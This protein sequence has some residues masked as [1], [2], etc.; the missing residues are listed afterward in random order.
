VLRKRRGSI[1]PAV[2]FGLL[3]IALG[4]AA[5]YLYL[6]QTRN[7][8]PVAPT[9]MPGQ[10][11]YIQ[12]E[13]AIIDAGGDAV[14]ERENQASSYELFPRGV[15]GQAIRIDGHLAWIYLFS[16]V[17]DREAATAAWEGAGGD[18]PPVSTASG[19]ELTTTAPQIFSGSNVIVLLSMDDEPSQETQDAIREAVENLP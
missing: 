17:E 7:E 15:P 14:T 1:L 4:I 2:F 19:R 10:N 13:N 12:V 18:I 3:A 11:T 5:V 9:A 6:E 16:S 8:T